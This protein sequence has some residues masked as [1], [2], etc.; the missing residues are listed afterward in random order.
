ML[1]DETRGN[2]TL[3]LLAKYLLVVCRSFGGHWL[4][5]DLR[6]NDAVTDGCKK[7]LC[8]NIELPEAKIRRSHDVLGQ[9]VIHSYTPRG[10]S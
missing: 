7:A 8:Y 10:P 1:A 3:V 9:H 5:S 2:P 6:R 4:H